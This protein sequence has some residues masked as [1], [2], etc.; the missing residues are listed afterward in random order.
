M[1]QFKIISCQPNGQYNLSVF[2]R[3]TL[4]TKIISKNI[5][6]EKNNFENAVGGFYQSIGQRYF[7]LI[8]GPLN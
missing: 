1:K 8:S 3:M 4:Y 2:G 5:I 6:N 7:Q